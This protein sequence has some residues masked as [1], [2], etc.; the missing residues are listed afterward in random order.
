MFQKGTW[1]RSRFGTPGST[2]S[3]RY[4]SWRE[5]SEIFLHFKVSGV[6]RSGIRV[7][8]I[9]STSPTEL[10]RSQTGNRTN[11]K[12]VCLRS[13]ACAANHEI[14][15]KKNPCTKSFNV[16][17]PSFKAFNQAKFIASFQ[18]L[19]SRPKSLSGRHRTFPLNSHWPA[20]A[21]KELCQEKTGLRGKS[22]AWW[23]PSKLCISKYWR[24]FAIYR[25]IFI[26]KDAVIV[27][28]F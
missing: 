18:N 14:L 22:Y 19:H 23:T 25:S 21:N 7:L 15:S 26:K 9:F 12:Q 28:T 10:V 16:Y 20:E 11:M 8:R 4:R 17:F 5:N 6:S 2:M 27:T 13:K 24:L 3:F 1:C